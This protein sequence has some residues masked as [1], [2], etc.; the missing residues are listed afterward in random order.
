MRPSFFGLR[1]KRPD[2][3]VERDITDLVASMK[4]AEVID[5]LASGEFT[6]A[7]VRKAEEAGKNRISLLNALPHD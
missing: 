7:E 2:A 6:A 1:R 4:V 3:P 5:K